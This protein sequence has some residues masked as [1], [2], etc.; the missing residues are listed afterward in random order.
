MPSPGIGPHPGIEPRAPLPQA[1]SSPS[2][3]VCAPLPVPLSSVRSSLGQPLCPRLTLASLCTRVSCYGGSSR[4][5]NPRF[6]QP[7]WRQDTTLYS[8]PDPGGLS[9]LLPPQGSVP[10]VR[11]PRSCRI[12]EL[13]HRGCSAKLPK[14]RPCSAGEKL[15]GTPRA[16]Q[17]VSLFSKNPFLLRAALG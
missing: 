8:E 7:A 6:S 17:G 14:S 15:M 11:Q 12:C 2:G 5:G 16:L 4:S 3:R 9:L 13:P 10:H 1:A